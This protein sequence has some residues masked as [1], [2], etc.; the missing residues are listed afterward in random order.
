MINDIHIINAWLVVIMIAGVSGILLC[1]W[2][3]YRD[4]R[5]EQSTRWLDREEVLA[6]ILRM[7]HLQEDSVAAS[8]WAMFYE[9]IRH[10]DTDNE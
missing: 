9:Y 1:T 10:Y 7:A 6:E 5:R 3:L 4:R 2:Y 8:Y